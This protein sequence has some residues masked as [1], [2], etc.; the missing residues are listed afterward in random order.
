M[1]DGEGLGVGGESLR[2]DDKE[3]EAGCAG[4]GTGDGVSAKLGTRL[5]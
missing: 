4:R 1:G 2:V 3:G 5:A